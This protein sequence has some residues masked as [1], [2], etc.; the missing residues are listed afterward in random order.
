MI[1]LYNWLYRYVYYP[2]FG[3]GIGAPCSERKQAACNWQN[4]VFSE[5]LYIKRK[6]DKLV[7]FQPTKVHCSCCSPTPSALFA[8]PENPTPR[9]ILT[10]P[11][12]LPRRAL[13]L[14]AVGGSLCLPPP[15][16]AVLV[17]AVVTPA[18]GPAHPVGPSP[19]PDQ[20][21]IPSSF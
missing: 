16:P 15:I 7:I 10:P 1:S 18:T 21:A 2:T 19:P 20:P 4:G 8:K 14:P 5:S 3:R 12:R 11:P 9:P 17:P 6:I 13:P